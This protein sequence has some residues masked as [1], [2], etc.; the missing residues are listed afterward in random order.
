MSIRNILSYSSPRII[1]MKYFLYKLLYFKSVQWIVMILPIIYR[2]TCCYEINE[3]NHEK[4][5]SWWGDELGNW[6]FL[7]IQIT[8]T[9]G[10][11]LTTKLYR[12]LTWNAEMSQK[13][14]YIFL[15]P[16]FSGFFIF[17]SYFLH[18]NFDWKSCFVVF[19]L[20]ETSEKIHNSTFHVKISV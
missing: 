13:F 8:Y 3:Y 2:K 16:F 18:W 11:I 10:K 17:N 5:N 9:R 15:S 1:F 20:S 12:M 6:K 4:K 14:F 7:H 19:F